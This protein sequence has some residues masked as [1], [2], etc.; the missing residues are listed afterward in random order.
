MPPRL[1]I[2]AKH[3]SYSASL[4]C[5]GMPLED[6]IIDPI[7]KDRNVQSALHLAIE[8]RGGCS[9]VP[10]RHLRQDGQVDVQSEVRN[11]NIALNLTHEV[12]TE[13]IEAAQG[14]EL[15]HHRNFLLFGAYGTV[16]TLQAQC[17]VGPRKFPYRICDSV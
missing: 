2:T 17:S 6:N 4:E 12:V 10:V 15:P 7:T 11:R 5:L 1:D 3:T 9:S 8:S 13:S 14:P 16:D